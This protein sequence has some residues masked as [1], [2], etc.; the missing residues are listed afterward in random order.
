MSLEAHEIKAIN[1]KIGEMGIYREQ[2]RSIMKEANRLQ[3][4]A[5]DGTVYK[6]FVNIIQAARRGGIS[7]EVLDTA[8][9]ANIYSKLTLAYTQ[10][11][12]AAENSLDEP[13][14]SG[15]RQREYEKIN[16]DY[17]QKAGNIDQLLVPT[18]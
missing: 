6:G 7:S 3:Y 11:K 18:R 5:P 16:S 8:K 9:F 14:R 4:T 15:I 17:N 10:S 1:S 13:L 2:I 12:V